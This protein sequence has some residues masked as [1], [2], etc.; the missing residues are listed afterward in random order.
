[1]QNMLDVRALLALGHFGA[2]AQGVSSFGQ[3]VSHESP[4]I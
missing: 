2:L 1:M 3:E 4:M